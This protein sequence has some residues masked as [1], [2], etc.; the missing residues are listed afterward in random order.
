MNSES[1]QTV[2]KRNRSSLNGKTMKNSDTIC[3][4][5]KTIDDYQW[6]GKL[7]R[8]N[9]YPI[10]L[11]QCYRTSSNKDSYR[12]IGFNDWNDALELIKTGDCIF[13]D[14]YTTKP[15]IDYEYKCPFEL[16]FENTE[17]YVLEA[18][19]RLEKMYHHIDNA[20]TKLLETH[21]NKKYDYTIMMTKSHGIV[22]DKSIKYYKF[23]Y[24]FIVN[25]NYYFKN[26]HD[27]KQLAKLIIESS[28]TDT[29]QFI[30]MKVYRKEI[31]T[32]QKLRCIYSRKTKDDARVLEPI[33]MHGNVIRNVKLTDYLV[34]HHNDR[35]IYF[36]SM[37]NTKDDVLGGKQETN[38]VIKNTKGIQSLDRKIGQIILEKIK[39]I[40]PSAYIINTVVKEE[41]EITYHNFNYNH[42]T[43]CCVHG[44][45]S[46]DHINGYA[47]IK[48]RYDCLCRMLF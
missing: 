5:K 9:K 33:D 13:E 20:M 12:F 6:F 35:I 16:Y 1:H 30:D 45:H 40:I 7:Y 11:S 47:Y 3:I 41:E 24:H 10:Q 4:E 32:S 23:S 28:D 46:H 8:V 27:A 14:F 22:T 18:H 31:D 15:Y 43:D 2:T 26:S 37:Q 29:T 19:K 48:K 44:N 25:C 42:M 36:P 17:T 39:E 21:F 38:K 34:S